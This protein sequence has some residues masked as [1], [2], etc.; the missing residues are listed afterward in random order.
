ML[1][2]AVAVADQLDD[3]VEKVSQ[4][5][6]IRVTAWIIRFMQNSRA[7]QTKR[8]EGLLTADETKKAELF[9]VKLVQARPTA[10]GRYQEDKLQLNLQ[11]NE[12]GVL[13]CCGRVQGHYPFF[14]FFFCNCFFIE[15]ANT[16]TK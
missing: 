16:Q 12:D 3:L 8:L 4:W 5:K 10:D 2:I 11:E 9:W 7:K 14:F 15:F 6:A 1:V 13:E